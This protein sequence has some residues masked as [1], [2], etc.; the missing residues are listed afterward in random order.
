MAGNG[1][2]GCLRYVTVGRSSY[3]PTPCHHPCPGGHK[4]F[5]RAEIEKIF[6]MGVLKYFFRVSKFLTLPPWVS[7]PTPPTLPPPTRGDRPTVT[8]LI[9]VI[10]AF[11]RFYVL[12]DCKGRKP[13]QKYQ[14]TSPETFSLCFTGLAQ[15]Y[16]ICLAVLRTDF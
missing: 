15:L 4:N 9:D 10:V 3:P 13:S 11:S 12:Q 16:L 2:F 8:S 1:S 5:L 6:L 14:K 7:P